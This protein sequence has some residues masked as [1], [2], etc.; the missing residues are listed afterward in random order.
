MGFMK[1]IVEKLTD[2]DEVMHS[3]DKKSYEYVYEKYGDK[4]VIDKYPD[5][6]CGKKKVEEYPDDDCEVEE[7]PPTPRKK[8]QP[9]SE[10]Q[11]FKEFE[12]AIERSKTETDLDKKIKQIRAEIDKI[13]AIIAK[14]T[15]PENIKK[16]ETY[17]A[18]MKKVL[19][20]LESK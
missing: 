4:E 1:K 9:K 15:N 18:G 17:I 8:K 11:E 14:S 5:D 2:E 20:I 6:Y 16:M 19:E 10:E 3:I 13:T 12:D 7:V